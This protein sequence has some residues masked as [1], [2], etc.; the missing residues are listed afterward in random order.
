MKYIEFLKVVSCLFLIGLMASCTEESKSLA[1][2][3]SGSNYF[4]ME[5]GDYRLYRVDSLLIDDQG[6]THRTS[7]YFVKEEITES[8]I[9]SANELVYRIERSQSEE[10]TG[11]YRVTDVWTAQKNENIV[12]RVE[13]NLTFNKMI[14]PV[15]MNNTWEGNAFENLTEVIVAGETIWV[16]K[17]WGD[18]EIVADG[19]EKRV[20]GIDYQDVISV[21]QAD[22]DFGIERR[23]AYE[24]YAPE[25]GLIS[26]EMLILDTQCECPGQEWLEKATKGF[27]LSQVLVEHN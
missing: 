23:Y 10:R 3:E 16:Y 12:I 8:F 4:P 6:G 21:K 14:F 7:Q 9:N 27:K 13:E 26:K 20:F 2:I 24:H 1:D 18:Y 22:H 19:I 15:S 17:D 11:F 5:I 25:V